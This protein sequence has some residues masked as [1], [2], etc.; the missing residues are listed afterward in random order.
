MIFFA[1]VGFYSFN[2]HSAIAVA[3]AG[4]QGYVL[5]IDNYAV[6]FLHD[7]LAIIGLASIQYP[8]FI[9]TASMEY[10]YRTIRNWKGLEEGVILQHWNNNR[11]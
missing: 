8:Y 7:D 1:E 10:L 4:N 3:L 5:R 2:D 11:I 9:H 6:H